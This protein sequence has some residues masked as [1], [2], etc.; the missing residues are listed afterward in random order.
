MR[1]LFLIPVFLLFICSCTN[2]NGP[3]RDITI[4]NKTDIEQKVT[5]I[6]NDL[7]E[8]SYRVP[9][10]DT[11]YTTIKGGYRVKQDLSFKYAYDTI[12]VNSIC[13]INAKQIKKTVINNLPVNVTLLDKADS[14]F[15][16]DIP[17]SASKEVDLYIIEH[18]LILK[19]TIKEAGF[20]YIEKEN[21]K[22]YYTI[23]SSN[24][25]ILITSL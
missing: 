8:E 25:G 4:E 14:D 23:K 16:A 6:I 22:Y 24:E 1:K 19:D 7:R 11:L 17:A 20:S 12:A 9:A 13:I 10:H 2:L 5:L 18:Q 21:T 15:S 3:V